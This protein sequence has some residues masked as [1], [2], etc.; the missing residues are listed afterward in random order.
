[1]VRAL[2][3][4]QCGPGSIPR[5]G[6]YKNENENENDS[7]SDSDSDNDPGSS[8]HPKVVFREVLPLIE[9]EFRNV[10]F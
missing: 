2:T 3:S 10:G 9:L 5:L 4:H 1:M 8:T 7:D 6:Y